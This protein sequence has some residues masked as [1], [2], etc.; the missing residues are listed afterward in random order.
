MPSKTTKRFGLEMLFLVVLIAAT[1]YFILRGCD[2]RDI[3]ATIAAAN[4]WMIFLALLSMFAYLFCGGASMAVLM[5]SMGAAMGPLRWLKYHLIEFFFSA[6]TPSSSGGQPMEVLV[7]R[8]DGYKI[9]ESTAV[10]LVVAVLFKFAMFVLFFSL[11]FF[12]FLFLH[13]QVVSMWFLFALGLTLN[14]ALIVIIMM[15][16]YAQRTIQRMCLWFVRLLA[17][18]K[19]VKH[20]EALIERLNNWL[21]GFHGCATFMREHPWPVFRSFVITVFQRVFF[22][23]IPYLV[24][25]SLGLRAV[26]VWQM[27]GLQL[28]LSISVELMPLPGAVGASESAFLVLYDAIFGPKYVY[29]AL[30]LSRGISHYLV[31]VISGIVVLGTRFAQ[32]REKRMR[33]QEE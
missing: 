28:L 20:S 11:Y 14:L 10:L 12:N 24:Y 33:L 18:M 32:S 22:L 19:L 27:M 25:R 9:T 17:R 26:T 5:Q 21:D 31:L 15:A 4:P 7:M 2:I 8:D 6:L 16:L 3:L 23:L 29:S 30:M 13:A 1:F